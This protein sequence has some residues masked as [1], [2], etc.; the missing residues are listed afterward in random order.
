MPVRQFPPCVGEVYPQAV[1]INPPPYFIPERGKGVRFLLRDRVPLFDLPLSPEGKAGKRIGHGNSHIGQHPCPLRNQ[2]ELAVHIAGH[3]CFRIRVGRDLSHEMR[4]GCYRLRHF[5]PQ[6]RNLPFNGGT[7]QRVVFRL[8]DQSVQI[9]GQVFVEFCGFKGAF[10]IG[11]F[12]HDIGHGLHL[13]RGKQRLQAGGGHHKVMTQRG[14]LLHIPHV[15]AQRPGQ[16]RTF[17]LQFPCCIRRDQHFA[18]QPG[19][20]QITL[21]TRRGKFPRFGRGHLV[22]KFLVCFCKFLCPQRRTRIQRQLYPA[23]NGIKP[24]PGFRGAPP[25]F[26][27]PAQ[28]LAGEGPGLMFAEIVPRVGKQ[29]PSR[30]FNLRGKSFLHKFLRAL[31]GSGLARAPGKGTQ[32]GPQRAVRRGVTYRVPRRRPAESLPDCSTHGLEQFEHER[33]AAHLNRTRK[34][35]IQRGGLLNGRR[36]EVIARIVF[37]YQ[38]IR[39][40]TPLLG[41]GGGVCHTHCTADSGTGKSA[42]A[43]HNRTDDSARQRPGSRVG[44][45]VADHARKL[46]YCPVDTQSV[47]GIATQ[48]FKFLFCSKDFCAQFVQILVFAALKLQAIPGNA[49]L[50]DAALPCCAHV[51]PRA[52]SIDHRFPVRVRLMQNAGIHKRVIDVG[53]RLLIFVQKGDVFFSFCRPR[54]CYGILFNLPRPRLQR[55]ILPA[56][57]GQPVAH[58]QCPCRSFHVRNIRRAPGVRIMQRQPHC[59]AIAH[60]SGHIAQKILHRRHYLPPALFSSFSS[61]S[62]HSGTI[63]YCLR[64]HSPCRMSCLV[65][66]G[67]EEKK[68]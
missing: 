7:F 54:I 18:V 23:G 14:G 32:G 37:L 41:I 35:T 46:L 68:G 2:A 1:C 4:G 15:P 58:V 53:Q 39:C 66:S 30:G 9:G 67:R 51:V 29:V 62:V 55:R 43:R 20:L 40:K 50:D 12:P 64:S 60:G 59:T 22:R 31:N 3:T 63:P 6:A 56:R 34:Q 24:R 44:R 33:I 27:H 19:G 28:T 21:H 61:S 52:G 16:I 47:G 42:D 5:R 48:R 49:V 8:F 13:F 17:L 11:T 26:Q 25:C 38:Q 36:P 65:F 45:V 10:G 57:V